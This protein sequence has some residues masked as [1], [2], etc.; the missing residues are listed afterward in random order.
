MTECWEVRL[1]HDPMIAAKDCIYS[2]NCAETGLN[3]NRIVVGGSGS[4][5]TMSITEPCLLHSR[6]RNLI[7]TATKARIVY[8]YRPVL[9]ERGYRVEVLDFTNLSNCTI[10]YDPM[11]FIRSSQDVEFLARSLVMANPR[12]A[13]SNAD[14]YWDD[15]SASVLSAFIE[16][17]R[18]KPDT[19]C[20]SFANVIETF[21]NLKVNYSGSNIRTNMDMEFQWLETQYPGNAAST[22]WESFCHLAPR[23]A[24]CVVSALNTAIRYLFDQKLL[25]TMRCLRRVDFESFASAKTVLF[26][27]TSP[28]NL[29]LSNLISVF[30]ATALK[31]LF[32]L[33]ERRPDGKLP[34]PTHII[35]DDFATG[36]PIPEFANHISIIREKGVSVT[37]LCQSESQLESMYSPAEAVTIINNCDTYVFTGG[38]DLKTAHSVSLRTNLPIDEV[39]ALPIGQF[40]VFRRGQRPIRSQRY[41][42]L[43]DPQYQQLPTTPPPYIVVDEPYMQFAG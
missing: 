37:L 24:S 34:I 16:M 32:E 31:E 15:M 27:I 42:I 39:L 18:L 19:Q 11:Q 17:E 30:Y 25:D 13:R 23:T 12:K 40:V 9:L 43:E 2:S 26:L 3:N 6:E 1:V 21:R 38:M 29:A 33:A 4:G 28:V 5:K 7:V 14:P 20:R 22:H 8:Q 41:P 10:G 35:C 36:T